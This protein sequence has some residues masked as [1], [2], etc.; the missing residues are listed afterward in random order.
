MVCCV[1]PALCLLWSMRTL[2][3]L[4]CC[5]ARAL[6]DFLALSAE[7]PACAGRPGNCALLAAL[8]GSFRHNWDALQ[9]VL[10]DFTPEHA[11]SHNLFV[12]I[13]S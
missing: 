2:L 3:L 4:R 1:R 13:V 5:Y 10:L 7:I 12:D 6:R 9:E 11:N 8:L